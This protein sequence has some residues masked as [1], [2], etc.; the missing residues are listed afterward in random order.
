MFNTQVR[1]ETSRIPIYS[2]SAK[3]KDYIGLRKNS[4]SCGAQ[5]RET[6]A[7]KF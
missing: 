7:A 2:A 5:Q 3:A 4:K 6:H 1:G